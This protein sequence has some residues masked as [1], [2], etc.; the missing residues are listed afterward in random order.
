LQRFCGDVVEKNFAEKKVTKV[1]GVSEVDPCSKTLTITNPSP[2][3]QAAPL[4]RFLS[5]GRIACSLDLDFVNF[6]PFSGRYVLALP[7]SGAQI[8][9]LFKS[10]SVRAQST[11]LCASPP[12]TDPS[13][14]AVFVDVTT[15]SG[16]GGSSLYIIIGAAVGGVVLI[17]L[18]I[19]LIIY[20]VRKK[21]HIE[22][23]SYEPMTNYVKYQDPGVESVIDFEVPEQGNVLELY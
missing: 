7:S 15:C 1:N 23:G 18:L 2:P 11:T 19:L 16:G 8:Q 21:K 5:S 22:G 20:C 9:G 13:S 6:P 14:G 3:T 17:L 10:V 4:I 12:A